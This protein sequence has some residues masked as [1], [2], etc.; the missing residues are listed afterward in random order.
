[1]GV[2]QTDAVHQTRVWFVELRNVS[3]PWNPPESHLR[4]QR[5][6]GLRLPRV[7]GL[8]QRTRGDP[9]PGVVGADYHIAHVADRR[10]DEGFVALAPGGVP[11]RGTHRSTRPGKPLR[12][13]EVRT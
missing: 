5:R 9:D 7:D 6:R 11:T 1:V 3:E 12:W 13:A 8:G 4:Q 2:A 10:A